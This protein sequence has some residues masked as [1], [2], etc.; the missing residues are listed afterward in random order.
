MP[1]FGTEVWKRLASGG[2]WADRS[3]KYMDIY[4]VCFDYVFK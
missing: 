1:Y 3:S 4:E 2:Q